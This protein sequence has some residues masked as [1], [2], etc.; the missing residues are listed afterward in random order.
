MHE[1][2]K[3][4]A[5]FEPANRNHFRILYSALREWNTARTVRRQQ[6]DALVELDAHIL[7]DIGISKAKLLDF[8]L[9]RT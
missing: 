1:Q 9:D 6:A 2:L 4:S 7:D 8:R 5:A 3:S